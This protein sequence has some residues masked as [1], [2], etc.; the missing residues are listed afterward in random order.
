MRGMSAWILSSAKSKEDYP[1]ILSRAFYP[2]NIDSNEAGISLHIDYSANRPG[3]NTDA[4][5]YVNIPNNPLFGDI[6]V[7][8]NRST[9]DIGHM[10]RAISQVQSCREA[11]DDETRADLNQLTSLYTDWAKSVDDNN[12]IIPSY[13]YNGNIESIKK[14][15]GDYNAYRVLGFD[16]TCV[17]KLAVRYMHTPEAKNLKCGNGISFLEKMGSKYLQNDAIEIL[18]SHHVA[19]AALA[20]LKSQDEDAQKLMEGLVNRMNRDFKVANNPKISPKYDLQDIPTFLI[21]ANNIGVPMTSDE[22]HYIYGRLNA[23]YTGL[24]DPALYNRL[25]IFDP[26]VPDGVYPYDP[27]HIGFYFYTIGVM[28]GSCSSTFVNSNNE[29]PLLDCDR[30]KN[31]LLKN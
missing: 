13:D 11:F 24:L 31:G 20:Q 28:L 17:E 26:K 4:S 15:I 7:K 27:P 6:W 19:A 29:R 3:Q 12:F 25:H 9:D 5:G 22:I 10:L 8:R 16:P 30:L 18:R 21:H 23:A 2:K 14:G 1:K